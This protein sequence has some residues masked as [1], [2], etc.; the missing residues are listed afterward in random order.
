ML[1]N[2]ENIWNA[3]VFPNHLYIMQLYM[4]FIHNVCDQDVSSVSEGTDQVFE[5]EGSFE[6]VLSNG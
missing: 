6:D 4:N 3:F 1:R 5:R 2:R